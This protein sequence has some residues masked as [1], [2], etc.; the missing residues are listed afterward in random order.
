VDPKDVKAAL[1]EIKEETKPTTSQLDAEAIA[2]A[3]TKALS[4]QRAD[5]LAGNTRRKPE[6]TPQPRKATLKEQ[7]AQLTPEQRA[8]LDLQIQANPTGTMFELASMIADEK[9]Q[10]FAQQANP[11]MQQTG[12]LFVDQYITRK[13]ASEPMFTKIEPLFR[14][15]LDDVDLRELLT[16]P[17]H[18]RERQLNLRWQAAEAKVYR[19]AASEA[20][21]PDPPV[22]S[23]GGYRGSGAAGPKP[24]RAEGAVFADPNLARDPG[25]S[26][27]VATMKR[28]GNWTDADTD[29]IEATY[30]DSY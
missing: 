15:E 16:L 14:Q 19:K 18:Q 21:R 8:A 7:L 25:L 1:D 13:S 5:D 27:L 9:M 2:T 30:E 29:E 12:D 10:H 6:P 3:V 17:A 26:A 23:G 11:F 28:R 24:K 22:I 20:P 4:A